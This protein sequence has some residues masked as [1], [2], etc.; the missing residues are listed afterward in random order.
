MAAEWQGRCHRYSPLIYS[1]LFVTVSVSVMT[2]TESRLPKQRRKFLFAMNLDM[3]TRSLLPKL[4]LSPVLGIALLAVASCSLSEV[5]PKIAVTKAET[6]SAATK[7]PGT[8][9]LPEIRLS[10]RAVVDINSLSVDQIDETVTIAGTVA[11]R[12]PLLEGWLYQV[13]DDS[14]S[15]WVVGDQSASEIAPEKGEAVMVEGVVRYEAIV[16]GEIDAGEVYLQA[17][18]SREGQ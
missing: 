13:R 15:L 18:S 3:K 10:N 16:V 4:L 6:E 1:S 12:V 17:Q 8:M 14:G 2:D 9:R 5:E 7:M 11:E